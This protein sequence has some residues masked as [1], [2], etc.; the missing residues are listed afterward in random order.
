M[1]T[2]DATVGGAAS[3]SYLT[4]AEAAT[5]FEMRTTVPGWETADEQEVLLMM[6]TRVMDAMA[7][8][9]ST[10]YP[11]PPPHTIT[12]GAW[13]GA[14]ATTTQRLAWPRT[15]MYD[16]NGNVIASNVIPLDLKYAT[17]ELAGQLG[18]ADSTVDNSVQIQG[19]TSI[20]AGSVALTF[21]DMIERHVIPDMVYSLM[22]S[23]WFTEEIY[24]PTMPALFDVVSE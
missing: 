21:K 9:H 8:P 2:L 18:T 19:I 10:Y 7:R 11:G 17:A 16:Q 1:A 5:Y 22:P 4:L 6:A 20:R 24:T 3:N 23:S 14:P 15:G 12:S 13:T